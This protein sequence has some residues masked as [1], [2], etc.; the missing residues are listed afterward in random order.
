MKE[1]QSFEKEIGD[2]LRKITTRMREDNN[3]AATAQMR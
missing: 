3:G 1:L 2:I